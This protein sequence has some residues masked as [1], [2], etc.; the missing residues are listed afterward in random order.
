MHSWAL[1]KTPRCAPSSAT[2]LLPEVYSQMDLKVHFYINLEDAPLGV[3]LN[4]PSLAS[5]IA[6]TN[7][8][9]SAPSS[10]T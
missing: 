6:L 7:A 9:L 10:A 2:Q 4:E 1:T 3:P 5:S 8:P